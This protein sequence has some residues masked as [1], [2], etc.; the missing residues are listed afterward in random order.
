MAASQDPADSSAADSQ[1]PSF[2]AGGS[3]PVTIVI[4]TWNGLAY[5]RACIESIR[6]H[7]A[8]IPFSLL[9]VDNGSTDGTREWL[10]N[11]PDIELISNDANVGYVRGN[12]QALAHIPDTHDVLL[13][14][15]DTEVLQDDWLRVLSV[16]A[17]RDEANGIVGCRLVNPQG[18]T[19]HLGTYMPRDTWRGFQLS[20]G[21]EDIGQYHGLIEV[22]GVVGACMYIRRDVRRVVGLLDERYQ[23]YYEDSDYCYRAIRAGYRVL[24]AA[25]VSLLHHE[26]VSTTVNNTA[27]DEVYETSREQFIERWKQEVESSYEHNLMWQSLVSQPG[28]YARSARDILV[29]LDRKRV[30]I[31]LCC[32]YGT[33]YHEPETGDPRI[34]QMRNRPKSSRLP[35]VLYGQGDLFYKNAGSYR[36]GFTML[37]TTGLPREWVNQANEMDEVWVPSSF[38]VETFRNSGVTRPLHV[39]PLGV[40]VRYFHPG[41][42]SERFS[43]RYTFLSVFEWGERKA[44]EVLLRAFCRAFSHTEDVAMVIKYSNSSPFDLRQF[45]FDLGLPGDTPPIVLLQSCSIVHYQMGALYRGAD[46]FVLPTRGEGWGMPILEAMACGLP[47]IAT[48]WSGQTAF[49]NE[50]NS[51]PLGVRKLIP[52][53]AR[54][55]YYKGYEWADP[56]EDQLVELMRHVFH[57]REEAAARGTVA[58]REAAESW[59][60]SASADRI[61]ERLR[62]I[63]A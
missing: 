1:V 4:L 34:D 40:D 52:A 48:N 8:G 21:E 41:I 20:A 29:E 43:D 47:V 24:C 61:V 38:N 19:C 22:E 27:F 44:P 28:G 18:I 26:H 33:D 49:M 60:W 14:N 59:S 62:E 54:C 55:P 12:N 2:Q 25:E 37:E 42:Q 56:D 58:A 13:L 23:S 36:I 63:G 50:R 46:C 17:N 31:R 39:I 15:N 35:Q 5:T 32:I 57:N 3:A 10:Q 6:R 16:T 7:R 53:E 45:L 30:D 51:Y 9:V 11:Q